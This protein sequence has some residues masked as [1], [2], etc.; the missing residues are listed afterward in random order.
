[1]LGAKDQLFKQG[2]CPGLGCRFS[3]AKPPLSFKDNLL[4]GD[5][6]LTAGRLPMTARKRFVG[7]ATKTASEGATEVAS[8]LPPVYALAMTDVCAGRFR[9]AMTRYQRGPVR[10][11]HAY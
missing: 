10:W 3:E 5:A 1:M 4:A 11:R 9:L 7:N 6:M 8:A 2:L